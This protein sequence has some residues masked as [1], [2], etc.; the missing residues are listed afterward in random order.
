L[1]SEIDVGREPSANQNVD[2]LIALGDLLQ[3]AERPQTVEN[4]PAARLDSQSARRDR[5]PL[6]LLRHL[7]VNPPLPKVAGQRKPR[8]TDACNE[9]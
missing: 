3:V 7:S 8:R 2:P 9:D 6:E 1:G 4:L 5:W